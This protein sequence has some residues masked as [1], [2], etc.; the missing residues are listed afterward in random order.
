MTDF[1][2]GKLESGQAYPNPEEPPHYTAEPLD[3][4]SACGDEIEGIPEWYE[5]EP[6]CPRCVITL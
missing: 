2:V 4:C 5:G 1:P 6:Y 3:I